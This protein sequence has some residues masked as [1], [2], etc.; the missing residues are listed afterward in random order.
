MVFG[1]ITYFSIDKAD[2]TFL[3]IAKRENSR[4]G[5]V[6]NLDILVGPFVEELNRSDFISDIF[7][8]HLVAAWV[9]DFH[10]PVVRHVE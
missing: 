2:F 3:Q 4:Q 9:L 5:N 6:A 1:A 8:Q 7:W 10:F